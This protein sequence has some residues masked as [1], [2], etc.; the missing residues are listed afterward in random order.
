MSSKIIGFSASLHHQFVSEELA[1]KASQ[2]EIDY[3]G[4]NL[5]LIHVMEEKKN[6][7]TIAL[8]QAVDIYNVPDSFAKVGV[9][10]LPLV[11][12]LFGLFYHLSF[13][14]FRMFSSMN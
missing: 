6:E 5:S 10:D 3:F 9:S 4:C 11:I 7:G 12:A 13:F 2:L 1:S 14:S 8:T